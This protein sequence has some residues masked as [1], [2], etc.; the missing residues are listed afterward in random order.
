MSRE[1]HKAH[2]TKLEV[3]VA[4]LRGE[5]GEIVTNWTLLRHFKDEEIKIPKGTLEEYLGS[6]EC[7]YYG[8]LRTKFRDD[9]VARLSE[10]AECKIGRANFYFA[11]VK[12][13]KLHDEAQRYSKYI[14]KESFKKKRNYDISH[15]IMPETWQ[16]HSD[17]HIEYAVIVKALAMAVRLMRKIDRIVLGPSS[18]FLWNEMRK[19]RSRFICPAK[20]LYI[21]LPY[22]NL[23][24]EDRAKIIAE[25]IR[26]G[27]DVWSVLETS[28]NGEKKE[29]LACKDWG[30]IKTGDGMM[31]LKEYPIISITNVT[32]DHE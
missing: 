31:M 28:V 20:A 1:K 16:E 26:D 25:E 11:S 5:V 7:A 15:K 3:L 10:L 12:L 32:L 13:D 27:K 24:M 9:I 18:I 4:N 8:L 14:E 17:I 23:S 6:E 19:R 21:L 30:A 2:K 29:L 22:L